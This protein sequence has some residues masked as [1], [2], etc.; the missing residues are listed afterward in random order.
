MAALFACR[1]RAAEEHAA[2]QSISAPAPPATSTTAA[3]FAGRGAGQPTLG[4]ARSEATRTEATKLPQSA[5]QPSGRTT[6]P[7]MI[8]R[9]GDV[10]LQVGSVERS[11]E[12]IRV[13]AA[14]LT[15]YV[16]N[17]AI[18]TGEHQVHSATLEVK[19]PAARFD[20]LMAGVRPLGEV[21]RSNAT[22]EDVGEEFVDISAR[23]A[24]GKRLE[25]RLIAL[26]A[27]RTGKLEDVL[28]VERE[29]ARV[30]EEIER[31]EGRLRYLGSRIA[32]STIM[33]TVHEKPPLVASPGTNVI[34]NAFVNMWR[35]FVGL[36]AFSIE[37]L[38]VAIPVLALAGL[39]WVGWKRS[40]RRAPLTSP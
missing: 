29:L 11:I 25:A 4:L 40:R 21:E 24:N 39:T 18:V 32:M 12:A 3:D 22:A 23:I 8:I 15:G 13:L 27:S 33:V 35:N 28:A 5:G 31:Y 19:V 9:N 16:G 2:A 10:S 17:V 36:V 26:L 6:A 20:D 38:G 30:R 1:D 37:A 34:R 14:S 7:S